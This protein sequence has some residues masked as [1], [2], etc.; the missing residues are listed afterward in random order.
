MPL[1][2]SLSTLPA[3]LI[4]LGLGLCGYYGLEWTRLPQYNES[5]IAASIEFNLALD[6]Q[7]RGPHLHPDAEK[8]EQLRETVR[9]EVEGEI[10]REREKVQRRFGL[11][12]I[13][14]VVGVGHLVAARM[15]GAP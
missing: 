8:L 3:F 5:D 1:R 7:R 13:A 2:R 14:L 15:I 10:S 11:G 9:A 12:L 6:L 4:A